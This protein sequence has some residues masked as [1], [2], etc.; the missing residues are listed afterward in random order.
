MVVSKLWNSISSEVMMTS[1]YVVLICLVQFGLQWFGN[2]NRN[3]RS[4]RS[5]VILCI[6]KITFRS[7]YFCHFRHQD[8]VEIQ[9]ALK[10]RGCNLILVCFILASLVSNFVE[11]AIIIESSAILKVASTKVISDPQ[12]YTSILVYLP[13]SPRLCQGPESKVGIELLGQLKKC[14]IHENRLPLCFPWLGVF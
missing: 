1:F 8:G 11:L 5:K 12:G 3:K 14:Q 9:S 4:W 13:G 10:S 2:G 7:F 6:F